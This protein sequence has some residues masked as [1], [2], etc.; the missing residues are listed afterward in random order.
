MKIMFIL[1]VVLKLSSYSNE[2]ICV[3]YLDERKTVILLDMKVISGS[4]KHVWFCTTIQNVRNQKCVKFMEIMPI[5][6]NKKFWFQVFVGR[7]DWSEF[8]CK[9]SVQ[10]EYNIVA[11]KWQY[12]STVRIDNFR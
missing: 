9:W 8:H 1:R 2:N 7:V 12:I 5:I 10:Q 3:N 4:K 11:S 6:I